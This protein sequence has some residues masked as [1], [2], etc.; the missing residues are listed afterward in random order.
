V[1]KNGILGR[2]TLF[3]GT[4]NGIEVKKRLKTVTKTLFVFEF[5]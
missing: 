4:K 2:N 3:L 1:A 5:F